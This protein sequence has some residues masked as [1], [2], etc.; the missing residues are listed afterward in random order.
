LH[1]ASSTPFVDVPTISV[2]LYVFSGMVTSHLVGH[3]MP[4]RRIRETVGGAAAGAPSAQMT[5]SEHRCR[6]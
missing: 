5:R 6:V 2:T 1:M 3:P 4:R